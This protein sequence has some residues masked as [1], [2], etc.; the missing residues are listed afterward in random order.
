MKEGIAIISM[1]EPWA[2]WVAK[3][4]KTIETRTHDKFRSLEGKVIG[5]HATMKWDDNWDR[6]GQMYLTNL[7]RARTELGIEKRF[8]ERKYKKMKGIIICTVKVLKFKEC[9]YD[10]ERKALI[11]CID[12]KRYGL[13]LENV[14]VLK[15]PIEVRGSQG[16]WYYK[17]KEGEI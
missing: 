7:Q 2:S 14:R 17:L 15:T 13:V 8:L 11:E 4:W 6:W 16:I 1:H 12:V 3:G 9:G 10:D 5:I